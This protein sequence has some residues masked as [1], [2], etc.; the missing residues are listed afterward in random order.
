MHQV[1]ILQLRWL[2]Y[3]TGHRLDEIEN[4]VISVF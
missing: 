1:T 4:E 3:D 2:K